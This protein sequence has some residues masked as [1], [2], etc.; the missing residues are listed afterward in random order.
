MSKFFLIVMAFCF[1]ICY[2]KPINLDKIRIKNNI[3]SLEILLVKE[4]IAHISQVLKQDLNKSS[5]VS[6]LFR[7]PFTKQSIETG[8]KFYFNEYKPIIDDLIFYCEPGFC[9]GLYSAI[10]YYF[11][12]NP[13]PVINFF[14]KEKLKSICD[15]YWQFPK[16]F[17]VKTKFNEIKIKLKKIKL[18]N[19]KIS[20]CLESLEKSVVS[21][22]EDNGP[23]E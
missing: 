12:N 16:K 14:E 20:Y 13:V 2:S 4:N 1:F 21:V 6:I 18:N 3:D 7:E 5:I 8:I 11:L 9:R 19:H 15:L 10:T 17:Q 23:V 22:L